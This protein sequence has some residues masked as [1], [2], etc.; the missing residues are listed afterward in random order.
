MELV[1]VHR[2]FW[3]ESSKEE[4]EDVTDGRREE[5]RTQG[6]EEAKKE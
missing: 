6:G 2:R 3:R 5:E 1:S 4:G